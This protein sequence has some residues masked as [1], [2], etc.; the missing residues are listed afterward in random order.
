M[1]SSTGSDEQDPFEPFTDAELT[2]LA[3]AADPDPVINPDAVPFG[4]VRGEFGD[5]LPAWYMPAPAAASAT[6]ARRRRNAMVG[7]VVISS[8]LL[9]NALGLCITYGRLEIPF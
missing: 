8:L 2:A 9:V 1:V 6:G 4:A 5:L 7:A 3:L